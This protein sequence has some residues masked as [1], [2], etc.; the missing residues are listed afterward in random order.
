MTWKMEKASDGQRPT[1]R[2]NGRLQS[3]HLDELKMQSRD[4]SPHHPLY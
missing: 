3:E 1:I 2:L 4:H